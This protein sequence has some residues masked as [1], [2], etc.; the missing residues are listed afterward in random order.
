MSPRRRGLAVR[1]LAARE[2][3]TPGVVGAGRRASRWIGGSARIVRAGSRRW[4]RRRARGCR[5]R[6][7]G[8]LLELAVAL[9]ARAA[10]AD[11]GADL[12]I[13]RGGGGRRHRR[14]A[15]SSATSRR[16]GCRGR[17]ARSARALGRFEAERR[18]SCGPGTRC[19]A[20]WSTARKAFLFC[21]IDDHSRLLVGYRWAHPRGRAE[22]VAG[23]LRAG[24]AAR[25]VPKAVYVDNGSPFVSGQLLR[26][27]AVLGIRLIH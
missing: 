7:A 18:T 3:L 11:G 10:G 8:A 9:R 6:H 24:I 14:R 27:C 1:E 15:R 13:I 17:A 21:F 4:S 25:G 16:P 23:A 12:R 20:R 22:R 19:T 2:H 26:A 5:A